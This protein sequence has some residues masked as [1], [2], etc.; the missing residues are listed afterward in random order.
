[1]CPAANA[2]MK[3]HLAMAT[4]PST[5]SPAPRL[6]VRRARPEDR[7]RIDSLE[8]EHKWTQQVY[9]Y[10]KVTAQMEHAALNVVAEDDEARRR[11]STH[12]PLSPATCLF[13]T[14]LVCAQPAVG[15]VL[16]AVLT[17]LFS[18]LPDL[19]RVF[20]ATCCHQSELGFLEEAN[21][22][23]IS[24]RGAPV[25]VLEL[26]RRRYVPRLASRPARLEDH[27]DLREMFAVDEQRLKEA[28]GEFFLAEVIAD[29][30]DS[31]FSAVVEVDKLAV[32]IMSVTTEVDL[33][34][35]NDNFELAP[36]HGLRKK[37][38]DDTTGLASRLSDEVM[39]V[40]PSRL[41][42]VTEEKADEEESKTDASD[43]KDGEAAST[44]ETTTDA[45]K[46]AAVADPSKTN[47]ETNASKSGSTVD[48]LKGADAA[49]DTASGEADGSSKSKV[50]VDGSNAGDSNADGTVNSSNLGASKSDGPVNA[51][52]EDGATGDT[53][54]DSTMAVSQQES[55][56]D[57]QTGPP[58]TA[59]ST[60]LSGL[61]T[62]PVTGP[63]PRPRAVPHYHGAPNA[64][65]IN[66]F[67]IQEEHACRSLDLLPAVLARLP[68][69]DYLVM[70]VPADEP[71][72]AAD[73][74]VHLYV[75]HRAS[76]ITDFE[77]V[78]ARSNE[79]GDIRALVKH[80]DAAETLMQTVRGLFMDNA[81]E[82]TV[83]VVRCADQVVGVIVVR[84]EVEMEYVRSHFEVE[85]YVT[86]EHHDQRDGFGHLYH[87]ALNPI[88]QRYAAVILGE[89]MRLT[90]FSVLLYPVFP[91][92][93]TDTEGHS[94]TSALEQLWP[95]ARINSRVV[96]VGG[97]DAGL[98]VLERL[99]FSRE[100][101][102]TNLTLVEPHGFQGDSEA[103]ALAT[104]MCT[105]TE[106]FQPYR[107]ATMWLR[108]WV[109]LVRGVM[110]TIDR[111]RKC[112]LVSGAAEIPYDYLLLTCGQQF[113]LPARLLP[114]TPDN[115][116]RVNSP[117]DAERA[118]EY[119]RAYCLD[120]AENVIVYGCF[121][122][123]LTCLE[124]LIQL[125]SNNRIYRVQLTSEAAE[126]KERYL[127]CCGLFVYDHKGVE[128]VTFKALNDASL[129]FDGRLVIDHQFSTN[130]ASI[131]A[132]GTM[133]KYSRRYYADS[134]DHFEYNS[135]DV[136]HALGTQLL[137]VF[138]ETT[139]S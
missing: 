59:V 108:T 139:S 102:F 117:F 106:N 51:P 55:K 49:K 81:A 71:E 70:T 89:V 33:D 80:T 78:S 91:P 82:H 9:G 46:T 20:H 86:F 90:T 24:E 6:E 129:V 67:C 74:A 63:P 13:Q 101:L 42:P 66:L 134:F 64:A 107:L 128:L 123:A 32:G 83:L 116:F 52:R 110:H 10:T 69:V 31:S 88:F 45:S 61:S 92:G 127:S 54:A 137:K 58:Y 2:G 124:T 100:L 125:P 112:I 115:V 62:E 38:T 72:N 11:C 113:Q 1:M 40:R 17:W 43:S 27:D 7:A 50:D 18:V 75:F 37:T 85:E 56:A 118:L 103:G 35:L 98:A 94:L 132:V 76:L 39:G 122:E 126:T 23:I 8:W 5:E 77:V 121:L 131:R 44:T 109:N 135:R 79:L 119:V 36:F 3:R 73:A 30:R 15:A 47:N 26:E 29:E 34:M 16:R 60:V 95:R 87:F 12:A 105:S 22:R 68:D 130:D 65:A 19:D 138:G 25:P 97:G 133:T 21:F 111:K 104:D 96:V 120:R 4:A 48:G 93:S 114:D 53:K 28:Y 41:S 99:V 84:H 136:G 57:E 14:Q